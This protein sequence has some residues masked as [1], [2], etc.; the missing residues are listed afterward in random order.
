MSYSLSVKYPKTEN[1]SDDK[2]VSETRQELFLDQTAP[3][4]IEKYNSFERQGYKIGVK[5]ETSGDDNEKSPFDI[6]NDLTTLGIDYVAKLKFIEK[7]NSGSY[8]TVKEL[9]DKIE[10][11]GSD[12]YTITAKL[13]IHEE[14]TIDF[15]KESSWFSELDSQ[16]SI[17]PD[18]KS[19]N[20][21]ELQA[22]YEDLLNSGYPVT[23][24]IK[25]KG[26]ATSDLATQLEAYPDDIGVL[27]TLK[28]AE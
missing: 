14:S 21:L 24:E 16:Y 17:Q 11:H 18:V 9:A 23:L 10:Q 8:E 5:L 4:I 7:S 15:A 28:D 1:T 20:V 19:S 25:P 6:A 26:S 3:D 13:K 2:L 22:I 27:F 12:K